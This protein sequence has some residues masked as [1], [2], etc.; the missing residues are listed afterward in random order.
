[1]AEFFSGTHWVWKFLF[2]KIFNYEF[3][4][5]YE[6]LATGLTLGFFYFAL[7]ILIAYGFWATG[8]SH[9]SCCIFEGMQ[10]F[11]VFPCGPFNVWRVHSDISFFSP[12]IG[13]L[14]SFL[15]IL[16]I[17]L[18]VLSIFKK[19]TFW[20]HWFFSYYFCFNLTDF[21]SYI[22]NF[23]LFVWVYFAFLFLVS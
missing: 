16:A 15:V 5:F 20:F 21:C 4:F 1:M 12:T 17:G 19:I 8:T 9:L 10:V 6:L 23:H 3:N 7:C 11:T 13:N 22:Y 18:P 2:Q 14:F